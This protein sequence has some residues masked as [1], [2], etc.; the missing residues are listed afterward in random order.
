LAV[1]S[2]QRAKKTRGAISI[3]GRSDQDPA[4]KR[5]RSRRSAE[6]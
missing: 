4:S 3:R 5:V 2:D 1:I 6:I